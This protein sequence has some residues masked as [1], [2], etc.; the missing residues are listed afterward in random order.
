METVKAR[1]A[2]YRARE[3]KAK[4]EQDADDKSTT[5]SEPNKSPPDQ[6]KQQ[7]AAPRL[8]TGDEHPLPSSPVYMKALKVLLWLFLWGFF[9]EVEFGIAFLIVSALYFLY[10]SLRGSRRK[11][12]EPSAYS[13]F[14]KNCEA[15]EGTLT[16]EQFERE[17]RFGPSSVRK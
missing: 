3:N 9:I 12:W 13:V 4:D 5:R 6:E 14:N 1:L 15:I 2:A 8:E 7:M 11:P 16:A 17:L 10:V